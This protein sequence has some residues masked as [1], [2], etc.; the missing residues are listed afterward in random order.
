MMYGGV[1]EARSATPEIQKIADKVRP[2]LE[3]KTNE[4]YEKFEAVEYKTQTVAGENI[5]IKMDVG[6]DCFIHIKIFSGLTGKDNYELHGYQ[7]NKTRDDEL[8]YF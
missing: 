4:K 7:T 1:S 5:F 2:Q 3:A 6:H 8:T